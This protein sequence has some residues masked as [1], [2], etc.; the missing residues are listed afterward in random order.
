MNLQAPSCE[1]S[2]GDTDRWFLCS[3]SKNS[4]VDCMPFKAQVLPSGST[5]GSM[6]EGV[7]GESQADELV[8]AAGCAALLG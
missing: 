3:G 2:V 7:L 4:A 5:P 1:P 6:S 8:W